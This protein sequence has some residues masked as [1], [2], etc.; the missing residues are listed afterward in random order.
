M[1][2]L[3]AC[4]AMLIAT[5]AYADDSPA[6]GP[7]LPP[8]PAA[9]PQT[10]EPTTDTSEPKGDPAYGEKPDPTYDQSHGV[11]DAGGPSVGKDIYI[12]SYPDR[13]KTNVMGLAIAGGAAVVLG[14]IGLY[15]HL[16][17][18]AE[19]STINA[20]KFTGQAWT[21]DREA[22]Y[23][24]A[25]SS[26]VTAGV[27]YGIGGAVLLG[28]AIA[29][30]VTEPKMETI[31]IHPHRSPKPTALLAPTRGGAFVGGTWSF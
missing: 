9:P 30:M 5:R 24:D 21:P 19:S 15:F 23:D 12:K 14:G 28:T 26:A 6:A 7:T 4:V 18:R 1:R 25:H 17:S 2:A 27:L 22:T 8:G 29:Y 3:L 13:S 20:H 10:G 31:V 11:P 16:D